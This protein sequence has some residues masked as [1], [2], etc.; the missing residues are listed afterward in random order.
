MI[1][2][3]LSAGTLR[4]T[5]ALDVH[6][7]NPNHSPQACEKPYDPRECGEKVHR[8]RAESRWLRREPHVPSRKTEQEKPKP[9]NC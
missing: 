8:A 9:K 3:A 4:K 1:R 7:D 2:L 5:S 6:C